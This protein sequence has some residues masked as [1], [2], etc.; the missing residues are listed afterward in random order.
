M[1]ALRGDVHP[2]ELLWS[3]SSQIQMLVGI[4]GLTAGCYVNFALS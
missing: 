1:D 2:W 3:P 4:L